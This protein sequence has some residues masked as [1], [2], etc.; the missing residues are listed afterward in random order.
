M[1]LLSKTKKIEHP[2]AVK[3]RNIDSRRLTGLCIKASLEKKAQDLVILDL[4]GISS[5]T[6]YFVICSGSSTRQVKAI[7]E[8]IEM[9]LSKLKVEPGHIEGAAEGRWILMDYGD[10]VVHVFLEE[11]R[12]YYRLERLWGDAPQR[13]PE[14][15]LSSSA[16]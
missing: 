4:S 8:E 2:V 15:I 12:Q 10:A 5:F 16:P 3:G 7:A 1:N 6:D 14:Q 9:S 13:T 11:T